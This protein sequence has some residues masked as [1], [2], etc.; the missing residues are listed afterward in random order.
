MKNLANCTPTEFLCQVMKL[1]TPFIQW[2]DKVGAAELRKRV[3]NGLDDMS[4]EEKL[5]ALR[6]Q[7]I[8]NVGDILAAALE[9]DYNGTIEVMCISCF[10]DVE[11]VDSHPMVEYIDA[12]VEMMNSKE[13]RSFFTFYMHPTRKSFLKG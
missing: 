1:R 2:M 4:D 11:D 10:T 7:G 5:S 13:V 8:A 3:P 6:N 9:K 12:I